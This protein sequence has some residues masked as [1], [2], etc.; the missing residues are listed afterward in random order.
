M[1]QA[2]HAEGNHHDFLGVFKTKT[3]VPSASS[4]L[5]TEDLEVAV[6]VRADTPTNSDQSSAGQPTTASFLS[7]RVR[8]VA[9]VTFH[10][11]DLELIQQSVGSTSSLRLQ[12]G[13]LACNECSAISHDEFQVF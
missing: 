12:A 9:V 13:H 10:I 3:A 1:L 6:E 2:E 4:D 7:T 11:N 5:A 8:D